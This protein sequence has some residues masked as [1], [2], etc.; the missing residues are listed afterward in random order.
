MAA[1]RLSQRPAAERFWAKV[2]KTETCWLWTGAKTVAGYGQ[3]TTAGRT[4]GAHRWA[5]EH[6]VGPIPAG[7]HIDHLCRTPA[8]VNPAH[9]EPVTPRENNLRGDTF[10][11]KNVAKTHCPKGHAYDEGNTYVTPAY[12]H[13]PSGARQC[14][15]CDRERKRATSWKRRKNPQP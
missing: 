10:T 8:C 4:D 12:R 9:L 3:F 2:K 15:A 7:L 11:A 13:N 5:Y 6:L 14:R 1:T